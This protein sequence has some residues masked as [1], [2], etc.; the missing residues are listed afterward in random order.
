M[1]LRSIRATVLHHDDGDLPFARAVLLTVRRRL[2]VFGRFVASDHLLETRE[3]DDDEAA[4]FFRP[5]EDL[6]LAAAGQN[7]AAELLQYA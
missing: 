2:K 7:L 4:E 3:L 5:L 6:K 1:S